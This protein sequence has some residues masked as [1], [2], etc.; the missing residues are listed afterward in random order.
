VA[1]SVLISSSWPI[2]LLPFV[3][4]FPARAMRYA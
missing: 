1:A 4:I 3:F 2:V